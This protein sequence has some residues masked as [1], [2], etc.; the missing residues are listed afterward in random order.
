MLRERRSPASA[1]LLLA[2]GYNAAERR[3]VDAM[4]DA[5][6]HARPSAVPVTSRLVCAAAIL[7]PLIVAIGGY[8]WANLYLQDRLIAVVLGG[9]AT[10]FVMPVASA[11]GAPQSSGRGSF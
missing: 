11:L 1:R 3:T 5:L 8:S 2:A 10:A 9:L 4:L 6:P 7:I